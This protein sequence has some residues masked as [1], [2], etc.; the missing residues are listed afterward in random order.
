MLLNFFRKSSPLFIFFSKKKDL[1]EN[2]CL[3]AYKLLLIKQNE[4]TFACNSLT[5]FEC[6]AHAMTG[7]GNFVNL[8]ILLEKL[9]TYF[10]RIL[11]ILHYCALA[12][13]KKNASRRRKI[14]ISEKWP[15]R[16][17][18]KNEKKSLRSKEAYSFY[19]IMNV[20]IDV[21]DA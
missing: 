20:M 1:L 14:A 5:N 6:K 8:D 13:L 2:R 9:W 11:A 19:E 21:A 16:S 7:N 4:C 17:Y 15:Q 18:Q 12:V 3:S 10:R